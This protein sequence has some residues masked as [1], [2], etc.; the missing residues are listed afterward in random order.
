MDEEILKLRNEVTDK[1]YDIQIF[2]AKMRDL[3]ST[4]IEKN[5]SITKLNEEIEQ[6]KTYKIANEHLKK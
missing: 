1:D 5:I 6:I 3:E 2:K 4:I